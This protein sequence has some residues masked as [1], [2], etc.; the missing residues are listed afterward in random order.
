MN[1]CMTIL[2][3]KFYKIFLSQLLYKTNVSN[4]NHFH[5]GMTYLFFLQKEALRS[6]CAKKIII[7][8]DLSYI[9]F[10]STKSYKNVI[11]YIHKT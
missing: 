4:L 8:V 10:F 9:T 5:D 3:R 1:L 6:K 2:T 11:K 7:N